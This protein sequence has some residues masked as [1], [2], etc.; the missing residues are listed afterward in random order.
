MNTITLAVTIPLAQ[1]LS[2]D[3]GG[4]STNEVPKKKSKGHR[5]YFCGQRFM[6]K[7]IL[8][9]HISIHKD[10]DF[11]CDVCG[12]AFSA[13]W[14]LRKHMKT[15]TGERP[16]QCEYCGKTFVQKCTLQ[17]HINAMH[18][19][20]SYPQCKTCGKRMKCGTYVQCWLCRYEG[21]E[22]IVGGEKINVSEEL[23]NH[24]SLPQTQN[25]NASPSLS[26]HQKIDNEI[27]SESS[28]DGNLES[29]SAVGKVDASLTSGCTSY[30]VD[31]SHIKS[32]PRNE[33]TNPIFVCNH[34]NLK[35]EDS[36]SMQ[37][38]LLTHPNLR[39]YVCQKCGKDFK[40][41]Q[42]L[43]QHMISHKDDRPYICKICQSAFKSVPCLKQHLITHK[44]DR[45]FMCKDCGSR[46]KSMQGLKM[47]VM[48]HSKIKPLSCKTCGK[49]FTFLGNLQRH[50]RV[51]TG[52]RPYQCKFC[53][54]RFTQS[55]G[56]K[57][58]ELTHQRPGRLVEESTCNVCGR[59]F[60][61]LS[62]FQKHMLLHG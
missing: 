8:R 16:F 59:K 27:C 44:E 19:S 10:R 45:P 54:K 3:S 39:P 51:H 30:S 41:D 62:N 55:N 4:N 23:D 47:H 20:K 61:S 48:I 58:H 36:L 35:F 57:A 49:T 6:D 28:I 2:L 29:H 18:G 56:L 32:A 53:D 40:K 15:H 9:K 38:H 22:V 46:F 21:R 43:R 5:C 50:F 34:C 42:N 25:D 37:K 11:F 1:D 31:V 60:R 24:D 13:N 52:E 33:R 14:G 12:K 26:I 17:F 7:N